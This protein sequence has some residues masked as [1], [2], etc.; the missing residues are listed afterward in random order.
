MPASASAS[1][2]HG[3]WRICC[4]EGPIATAAERDA[5]S[6]ALGGAH[7]PLRAPLPEMLFSR[8]ALT[9]SHASGL[10]L[11][12]TAR[13]ALRAWHQASLGRLSAP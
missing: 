4:F 10:V 5:L 2:S 13:G 8:N 6:S 11:S 3:D 7:G 9:L 12:F 1:F